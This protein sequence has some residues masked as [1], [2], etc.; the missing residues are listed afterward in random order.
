MTENGVA[1]FRAAPSYQE[2]ETG[3]FEVRRLDFEGT[4]T[5]SEGT[6]RLVQEVPTLDSTVENETVAPV[7]EAGWE[8]T[9]ERRVEDVTNLVSAL[10]GEPEVTKAGGLLRVTM[11][12]EGK[13]S[14]LPEAVRN[15]ANYVESTWVEGIIPGFEYNE[16]VQAIRD[17]ATE[18]ANER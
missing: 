15:A 14:A 7:V 12:F 16:Q 17:R 18:T 5:V 8:D 13:P 4:V 3:V 11:T 10:T 6:V 9:F 1:A 2:Q